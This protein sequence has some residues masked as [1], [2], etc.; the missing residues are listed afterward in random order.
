MR[1]EKTDTLKPDESLT[2]NDAMGNDVIVV[3]FENDPGVH[4]VSIYVYDTDARPPSQL[5]VDFLN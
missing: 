5:G 1:K 3:H 2:I 4:L